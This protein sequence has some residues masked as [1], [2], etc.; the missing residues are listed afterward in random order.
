MSV[1]AIPRRRRRKELSMYYK[2]INAEPEAAPK[3]PNFYG[4]ADSLRRNGWKVKIS[5]RRDRPT[6]LTIRRRRCS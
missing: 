3:Q 4:L 2:A 5:L 6:Q 1:R